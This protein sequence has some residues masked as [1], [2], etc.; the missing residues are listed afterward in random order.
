MAPTSTDPVVSSTVEPATDTITVDQP[1]KD[2]APSL[3][4]ISVI[5]CIGGVILL[6]IIIVV[7]ALVILKMKRRKRRAIDIH[8]IDDSAFKMPQDSDIT[9][10]ACKD[11]LY[12]T[13]SSWRTSS[14]PSA[15]PPTFAA[16]NVM[17]HIAQE[18]PD[19]M[20]ME[21]NISYARV[22]VERNVAYGVVGEQRFQHHPMIPLPGLQ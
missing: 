6:A 1:S 12:E 19:G 14:T 16:V 15:P 9:G 18:D 20:T 2:Q 10:N 8:A 7:I 11:H 13:P 3:P 17:Y 4:V 5:I 22:N 21:K